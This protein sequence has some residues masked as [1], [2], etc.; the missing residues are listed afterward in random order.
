MPYYEFRAAWARAIARGPLDREGG[1]VMSFVSCQLKK[2]FALVCWCSY[3]PCQMCRDTSAASYGEAV[4]HFPL[5]RS[6]Q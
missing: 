6:L 5:A 2:T 3:E 1:L 4:L